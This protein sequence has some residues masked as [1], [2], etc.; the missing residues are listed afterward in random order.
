VLNVFAG[1]TSDNSLV[2]GLK[3]VRN[4]CGW[5]DWGGQQYRFRVV[6]IQPVG[7]HVESVSRGVAE[8]DPR[9]R[10]AV[11]IAIS[12]DGEEG[13]SWVGRPSHVTVIHGAILRDTPLQ[14]PARAP[15][16]GDPEADFTACEI[17]LRFRERG[18]EHCP[19]LAVDIEA[20]RVVVVIGLGDCGRQPT[21]ASPSRDL[22]KARFSSMVE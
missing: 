3:K 9:G 14:I 19:A 15:I 16:R 1:P 8:K 12:P 7:K 17:G 21:L 6:R 10:K 13:I 22:P 20:A 4:V 18:T 5:R 11:R 2:L